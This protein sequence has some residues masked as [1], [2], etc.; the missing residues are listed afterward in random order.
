MV[1]GRRGGRAISAQ[2]RRHDGLRLQH[3]KALQNLLGHE[4]AGLTL[5]HYGHLYGSKVEAVGVAINALLTRGCGQDV[6]TESIPA[7]VD[8][9]ATLST[10]QFDCGA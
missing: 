9:V 5:D 4:S 8:G 6:V 2:G 1:P 3:I 7:Q 10:R